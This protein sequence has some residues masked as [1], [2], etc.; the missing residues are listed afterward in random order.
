MTHS[1]SI[2]VDGEP[3][4]ALP[5]PDRGL[6]FGDGLF[7]TLL[8]RSGQPLFPELHFERLQAGL[9]VLGFPACVPHARAQLAE[10]SAHLAEHPWA[11]LRLTITRGGAPRGYAPPED[12]RPR[13]VISAAPLASDRAQMPKAVDLDWAEIRWASQ[14]LLAGIKH[15]NRLEQVMAA[16]EARAKDCDEVVVC[17]QAG[18]VCSVSA[19][20]LFL[21]AGNTLRTPALQTCGIAGTRRRLILERLAPALGLDLEVGPVEPGE[22]GEASELIICNSIRG[23]APVASLAGREWRDHPVCGALHAAYVEALSC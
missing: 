18:R 6:D 11:A 19:G 9:Q 22:L 2:W 14:H 3:A 20:N 5:L 16:R 12:V 1:P 23:I 15:L 13:I 8:L 7:E 21:V 4:N 10:A 17:D